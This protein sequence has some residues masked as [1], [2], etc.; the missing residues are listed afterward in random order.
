M[1][2]AIRTIPTPVGDLIAGAVDAGI[3]LLEFHDRQMLPTQ[4]ETLRRLFQGDLSEQDHPHFG[5]LTTQLDEYFNR[6]RNSFSVPLAYPG[7]PF[8]KKVWESL[9]TIPYGKTRTYAQQSGLIG[10]PK[11]IRAMARANGENRI[12]IL[13]PCHRVIG[14]NGEMVG[15]GGKIWRKKYLLELEGALV[16]Q[17]ELF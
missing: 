15:Y 2:I 1:N 12:A 7:S 13:I 11:A 8:Q 10:D 9:M 4:K 5:V 17:G 14:S 16:K 6:T 3:C